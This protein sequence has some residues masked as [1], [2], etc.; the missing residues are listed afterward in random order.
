MPGVVIVPIVVVSEY[1]VT[2]AVQAVLQLALASA[3]IWI[4]LPNPL[5]D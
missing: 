3:L 1:G 4:V 2:A 5:I